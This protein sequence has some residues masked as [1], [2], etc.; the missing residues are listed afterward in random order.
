MRR[1]K[2]AHLHL[3]NEQRPF[4]L[5]VEERVELANLDL[6]VE[7]ERCGAVVHV[8]NAAPQL[9]AERKKLIDGEVRLLASFVKVDEGKFLIC[10]ADEGAEAAEYAFGCAKRRSEF[11]KEEGGGQN[12]PILFPLNHSILSS[13]RFMTFQPFSGVPN[14]LITTP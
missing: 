7:D 14:S 1:R 2:V 9:L 5:D 6:R 10:R 11:K 8:G 13:A 3:V 4:A 12:A